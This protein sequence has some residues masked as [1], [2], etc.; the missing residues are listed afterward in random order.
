MRETILARLKDAPRRSLRSDFDLDPGAHARCSADRLR[1]AAVLVPIVLH[2]RR[3]TILLTRRNES[4]PDHP[5]QVSFPGGSVERQDRDPVETALREAEEEVG[6]DRDTVEIGGR[7]DPYVTVTGYRIDPVVGLV[8]PPLV[9]DPDPREVAAVFEVPLDFVLDPA[10]HRRISHEEQGMRR[11]FYAMPYEGHY[12][13]GATAHM[14]VN[15]AEI[16]NRD[17]ERTR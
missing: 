15:L 10:N 6:L 1:P 17:R 14:L 3:P 2:P 7:L 11:H 8:R 4:L 9:L 5:G 13:W 12:I 16:L